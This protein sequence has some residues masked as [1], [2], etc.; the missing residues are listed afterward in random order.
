MWSNE[1]VLLGEGGFDLAS[2]PAIELG[3]PKMGDDAAA[4]AAA[5]MPET[6]FGHTLVET[7]SYEPAR[8]ESLEG[9]FDFE[10]MIAN[11]F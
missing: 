8:H 10:D 5:G 4:A 9:L 7:G 1:E 11:G 6:L 2:I 3:V